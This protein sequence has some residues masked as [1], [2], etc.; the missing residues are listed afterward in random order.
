MRPFDGGDVA[1]GVGVTAGNGLGEN[2]LGLDS[3]TI[4]AGGAGA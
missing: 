1:A 4:G 3:L 2:W